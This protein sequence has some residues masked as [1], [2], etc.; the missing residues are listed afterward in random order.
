[1]PTP[2]LPQPSLLDPHRGCTVDPHLQT[3]P[4]SIT[5]RSFLPWPRGTQVPNL[6]RLFQ[7]S[8]GSRLAPA[9]GSCSTGLGPMNLAVHLPTAQL[10]FV[11]VS[12]FLQGFFYVYEGFAACPS[13]HHWVPGACRAQKALPIEMV[14]NHV[15][16]GNRT[17]SMPLCLPSPCLYFKMQTRQHPSSVSDLTKRSPH[18]G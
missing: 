2:P 5:V 18:I 9:H 7:T 11:F 12:L 14:V 6:A 8:P 3:A 10:L 1:M 16:A 13:V 4:V 15:G 17:P